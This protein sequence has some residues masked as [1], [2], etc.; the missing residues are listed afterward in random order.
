L[1][2]VPLFL[3]GLGA[4]AA[5]WFGRPIWPEAP[6]RLTQ[7]DLTLARS[8]V[9]K[10]DGN[11]EYALKLATRALEASQKLPDFMAEAAFLTGSIH[12]K[13]AEK[14]GPVS[15]HWAHAY[16]HLNQAHTIGIDENDRARLE[17]YLAKSGLH[18]G[19]DLRDVAGYLESA[20][21]QADSRVE[22]YSLLTDVYLRMNPPEL[23]KAL[24]A[25]L[26]LRNVEELTEAEANQAKLRGGD[27]LLRLGRT[28]EA[29][30]SLEKID[31][32]APIELIQQARLLRART[33]QAEKNWAEA[34]LQY[35]AALADTRHPPVNAALARYNLGLCYRGLDRR[36]E[37]IRAWKACL[38]NAKPIEYAAAAAAMAEAYL[39]EPALEPALDALTRAVEHHKPRTKWRNPHLDET[40]LVRL[41][42]R[43]QNAFKEAERYDLLYKLT[44]PQIKLVAP[45]AASLVRAEAALIWGQSLK[46]SPGL[47][48]A[49]KA[50][51][52]LLEAGST[53]EKA[54]DTE[55]VPAETQAQHLF[56]AA[57][58]YLAADDKNKGASALFRLR[59]LN[60]DP[61]LLGEAC[62]RLGEYYREQGETNKAN[63]M[64]HDCV[65]YNRRFVALARYR[66]AMADLE[67]G[68]LDD[69]EAGLVANLRALG[70]ESEPEAKAESLYALANLVYGK[71]EYSRVIFYLENAV[72][73]FH[74]NP[75]FKGTPNYTRLRYQ[76]A[77]AY[78]QVANR[79]LM[80]LL[81]DTTISPEMRKH[82]ESEQKL[83]LQ[84]AATE[85]AELD[86]F[87]NTEK[88][89]THLSPE[90]RVQVPSI[91]AKCLFN[92]GKYAEALVIYDRLA[93]QYENKVEGLEALGGAVQCH[94]ALFQEDKVRQRLLQIERTLP[95][96]PRNIAEEW[97]EWVKAAKEPLKPIQE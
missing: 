73:H 64:Y 16:A 53:F 18:I 57:T 88:G 5:A 26:K 49:Q 81:S 21:A 56:Q 2:H 17:Y 59:S 24:A 90:Q 86:K 58:A 8:A 48:D 75:R 14:A 20:A 78:R 67:A 69:A 52:L 11:L 43:A 82:R 40:Q 37:A 89:R 47:E 35:Q 72:V 46:K 79:E 50:K 70:W 27:I 4:L 15:E 74:N 29:R 76:L 91:L 87:L 3:L 66:L 38:T 95:H 77:D 60:A 51:D 12:L 84:K 68:R 19:K 41:F 83:Y 25:N 6:A 97:K 63:E 93:Q 28:Q 30:K 36:E 34:A 13:L 32:R 22:A 94:A 1:W 33:Y 80:S 10:A 71:R 45:E 92:L 7:R 96:V 62:Y 44:T 54:A 31:D 39:D 61:D 55:G 85:F 23:N 65:K 9:E 42:D